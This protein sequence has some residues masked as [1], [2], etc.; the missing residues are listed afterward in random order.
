MCIETSKFVLPFEL[1]AYLKAK[2]QNTD[3]FCFFFF[4]YDK[5][6]DN[7]NK[8]SVSITLPADQVYMYNK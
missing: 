4:L 3:Y 8:L 5:N 6:D 7:D 2:P 1:S